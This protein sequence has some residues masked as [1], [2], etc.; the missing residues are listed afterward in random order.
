MI[1]K[2]ISDTHNRHNEFNSKEL[3]CDI[4]IHAGDAC[5]KG[6]Y[7][8]GYAFLMWYVKQPA[9]YKILV[10]GN[11]DRK[12]KIH[13]DL[14]KLAHDL[15]IIV[16]RDDLIE[17]NGLKIYG[18]HTTFMSVDR[19]NQSEIDSR[20]EVWKNIPKG[21]DILITHMPPYGILDT[22]P[23]GNHCGCPK[24]AEKVKEVEPKTH[25]FGH[26]HL[27]GHSVLY[28]D[29][30]LYR[31]VASTNEQYLLIHKPYEIEYEES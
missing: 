9:K 16:L 12:L 27:H 13:N 18:N 10:C 6:N 17:I 2:C 8:E 20:V 26:I 31:N 11:H 14:I 29:G 22:N 28:K 15:G 21:L 24:L 19:Y 1:I 30:T 25:I 23:K 5:T 7:T 4:L 3:E